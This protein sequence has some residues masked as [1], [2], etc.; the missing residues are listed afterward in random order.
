MATG[1]GKGGNAF[2]KLAEPFTLGTRTVR[3]RIVFP[4]MA[5]GFGSPEGFLTERN[6]S[7]YLDRAR[8]G[9]GLIIVEPAA[10]SPDGR[11]TA[12]TLLFDDDRD[13]KSVV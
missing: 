3:N 7:Y 8:G 9:A 5:T 11:M 1:S 13:R 2:P 12:N 4:A 6:V 10:I